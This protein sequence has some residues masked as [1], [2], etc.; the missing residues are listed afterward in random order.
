MVRED[1]KRRLAEAVFAVTGEKLPQDDPLV[2]AALFYAETVRSAGAEA[3]AAI[4]AA[5][6]EAAAAVRAAGLEQAAAVGKR[7]AVQEG[8]LQEVV[9]LLRRAAAERNAI[10]EDMGTRMQKCLSQA[11][12][13]QPT[14]APVRR[15]AMEV[16]ATIAAGVVLLFCVEFVWFDYS[17]DWVNDLRTGR[18]FNRSVPTLDPDLRKR[19]IEHIEK[20]D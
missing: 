15:S 20:G 5:G 6:A 11:I 10:G 14:G 2:I 1:D 13:K 19:L 16:V 12:H 9:I 17:M 7:N 4:Q 3:A 8:A 18:K